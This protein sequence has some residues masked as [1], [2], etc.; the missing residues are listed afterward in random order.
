M[1][2]IQTTPPPPVNTDKL[3]TLLDLAGK[4]FGFQVWKILTPRRPAGLVECRQTA[5]WLCRVVTRTSLPGISAKFGK[6]H[7]G[8]VMHALR[9]TWGRIDTEP[10]FKRRLELLYLRACGYTSTQAQPFNALNRR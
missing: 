8:T 7:H 6:R 10:A 5:M 9:V 2:T 4:E 3:D 1:E